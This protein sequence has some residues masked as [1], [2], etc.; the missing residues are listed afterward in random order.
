MAVL[1][2]LSPAT[3]EQVG[4]PR[5]LGRAG[6]SDVLSLRGVC[7]VHSALGSA[8]LHSHLWASARGRA[9]PSGEAAAGAAWSHSASQSCCLLHVKTTPVEMILGESPFL[10]LS[11]CCT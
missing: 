2:H 6:S 10:C 8:K 4:W 5:S 9:V 7:N 1:G 11:F 3:E